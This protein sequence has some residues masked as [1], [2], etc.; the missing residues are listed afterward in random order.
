MLCQTRRPIPHG[1]RSFW[2]AQNANPARS[3]WTF[4]RGIQGMAHGSDMSISGSTTT[5]DKVHAGLNECAGVLAEVIVRS[6]IHDSPT[7][8]LF[9]PS[10]VGR[11]RDEALWRELTDDAD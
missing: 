7:L 1:H 2:A 8:H 9:R 6:R 3:E 10:G 4:A 11:G 5:A